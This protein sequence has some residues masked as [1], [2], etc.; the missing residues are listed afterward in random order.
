MLVALVVT[1]DDSAWLDL[2]AKLT[3]LHSS[4]EANYNK[5]LQQNCAITISRA[6]TVVQCRAHI[7]AANKWNENNWSVA[8]ASA[9][10][11]SKTSKN[12]TKKQ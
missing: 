6:I 4:G 10:A 2:A 5:Q 7:L 12:K 8:W 11:T 9:A 1:D 3:H